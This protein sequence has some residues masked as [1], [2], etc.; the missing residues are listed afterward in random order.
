MKKKIK[1]TMTP[2]Q[3]LP[4]WVIEKAIEGGWNP[5]PKFYGVKFVRL[6]KDL[7]GIE[8]AHFTYSRKLLSKKQ[9]GAYRVSVQLATIISDPSFWQ[10]L[11]KVLRWKEKRDFG[12]ENDWHSTATHFYDLILTKNHEGIAAFWEALRD[13]K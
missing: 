13:K 4:E 6:E 12:F 2:Q 10:A 5:F 11:G 1:K 9:L 3:F 8:S 7:S